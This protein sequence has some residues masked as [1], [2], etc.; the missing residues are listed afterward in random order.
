MAPRDFTA[1]LGE[2]T[3]ELGEAMPDEVTR[4]LRRR[5]AN[6]RS[7]RR[8]RWDRV[9]GVAV[10][11]LLVSLSLRQRGEGRGEGPLPATRE[12]NQRADV[13][14][15]VHHGNLGAVLELDEPAQFRETLDGVELTQGV[16]TF[17]VD[18]DFPR[19]APY[20]VRVSHGFIEVLGTRFT[21][22][23]RWGEGEVTLHRGSI[24]FTSDDGQVRQLTPGQ[25]L[26]WP[27]APALKTVVKAKTTRPAPKMV[28]PVPLDLDALLERVAVLR[29]RGEYEVAV[30]T[31]RE[32]LQQPLSDQTAERL[33][34]EL[35]S[36]LSRQ[37]HDEARANEHWRW[38]RTRF[39]PR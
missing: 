2:A 37:L 22:T 10:V 13:V 15:V 32:A 14:D 16:V 3:S 31:L 27:L 7:P 38:H 17:D 23:Q 9:A 18:H 33:S 28:E 6:G 24:R 25:T 8:V 1:S 20:R 39:G 21:V 36:I 29:S 4:R 11:L 30:V 19:A 12:T 34:F 26:R 5:L 35:G